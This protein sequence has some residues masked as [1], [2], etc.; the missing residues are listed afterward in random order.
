MKNILSTLLTKEKKPARGLMAF[1]WAVLA[2]L[3]V[4]TV[5]LMFCYTHL[6]HPGEMIFGR[7]K[8]L[9]IMALLWG[10]YRLAPCRL[11]V[12]LRVV[13]QMAMLPW[14]Y[15]DTYELNRVLPNLDHIFAAADQNLFGCQPALVFSEAMPW[16]IFSEPVYLGY[17]SYF[18][19]ILMVI[20]MYFMYRYEDFVKAVTIVLCSFFTYYII[21]DL[22]PVTGPQYYYEAIGM[23]NVRQGIFPDVG[24][25]FQQSREMTPPTGWDGFCRSLVRSGA[26]HEGERATAAFPS[27]HIGISTV[28][29]CLLARLCMKRGKWRAMYVFLPFFV[30]LCMATVYIRAH[31][32]VDAIAGFFSGLLLYYIFHLAFFNENRV[33]R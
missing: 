31:Y 12:F 13:G 28:V 23:D 2:Y 8:T 20:M 30:F 17:Y 11:T 16:G 10:V 29:G 3:L 25:Y 18:Y 7:V 32:L 24:S 26:V 4:T 9:V 14:W 15:T 6:V 21:F 19:L 33:R 27:S 22:V 5:M 1:E